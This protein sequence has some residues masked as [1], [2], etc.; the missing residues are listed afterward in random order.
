[1]I[2]QE[3]TGAS[4][5]GSQILSY[6][7]D[8]DLGSNSAFW[9]ELKGFSANDDTL[10]VIKT[11]LTISSEYRVRYRAKNIYGWSDYSEIT[12]IYTIMV[13]DVTSSA[14]STELV[15]TNVVFSWTAPSERG[16][17]ILYFNLKVETSLGTYI[18]HSDYCN[19]VIL[20]TCS[21]PMELLSDTTG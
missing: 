21:F 11:S 5:G 6:Q 7:I 2:I 8:Y 20:E 13:P 19:A 15:G 12:S 9:Q 18:Q 10:F 3:L 16:T 17:A 4:S 14:V 1:M